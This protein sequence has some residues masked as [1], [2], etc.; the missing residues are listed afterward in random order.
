M[1]INAQREFAYA[2]RLDNSKL[3][4]D[5]AT[6]RQTIEGVG[7]GVQNVG[8]GAQ[9][10]ADPVGRLLAGLN[11][12]GQLGAG[13]WAGSKIVETFSAMAGAIIT[14]QTNADRLI[15]QLGA[16]SGAATAG[17]ELE[18]IRE[19]T[20]RLGLQLNETATSYAR[21][22]ASARGTSL[23]GEGV[24]KIFESVSKASAVMGLTA[25]ETQGALRALEQMMSKG[26]VQAEEL[27]GQLGDRLPGAMQ[28]AARSMGVTTQELQKMVA[29]GEVLANDFLPKFA[30]QLEQELGGG[31]EAAGQRMAAAVNRM[32]NSFQNLS[33]EVLTGAPGKAV[34]GQLDI[35]SDALDNFTERIRD[36]REA[37]GGFW[38][39]LAAGSLAIAQFANP[40]NALG[41][42]ALS[43]ANRLKAANE[44]LVDLQRAL[45]TN[46]GNIFLRESIRDAERL[47][48]S[49]EAV[50]NAKINLRAIDNAMIARTEKEAEESSTKRKGELSKLL[51]TLTKKNLDLAKSE[52]ILAASRAAGEISEKQFLEYSKLASDR[53]SPKARAAA[54]GPAAPEVVMDHPP[55]SLLYADQ[56]RMEQEAERVE[57]FM[58]GKVAESDKRILAKAERISAQAQQMAERLGDDSLRINADLIADAEGRA[59]AML[60]IEKANL[61]SRIEAIGANAEDR[62]A[63]EAAAAQYMLDREKQLTEELKPEWQRRVEAWS[64]TTV[65]M[66]EAYDTMLSG[67]I[68]RGRETWVE[69]LKTGKLN[70]RALVNFIGDELAKLA[71]NKAI[72]ALGGGGGGSALGSALGSL[73]GML[74]IG[75]GVGYGVDSGNGGAGLPGGFDGFEFGGGL[76]TGGGAR[77]GAVHRIN[78]SGEPEVYTATN[79]RRY[80]LAGQQGWVSTMSA[81]QG[82]GGGGGG[83]MVQHITYNV[84][85]GTSP[86]EF[87]AMLDQN[88]RQQRA[89]FA[90][91]VSRPGRPLQ[92][93][94]SAGMA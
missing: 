68:D 22:S 53:F 60:A 49:L 6:A 55:V 83:A 41:Y 40:L 79:G 34:Q 9:E 10:A 44:N 3:D 77:A 26:T 59:R 87:R 43:F 21:F 90:A 78:E 82:G 1:A 17:K 16:A 71:Y 30:R 38:S 35:A 94:V 45:E 19:V 63:L 70:T 20:N 57:Q 73:L 13:G 92:R 2:I 93:A 76:A 27:R 89:Q 72:G 51:E 85:P 29:E 5:A 31:A 15:L 36:A 75:G 84:P 46:P 56:R 58:Q 14:A 18:Y 4:A 37:G 11:G 65:M 62:K 28:I 7:K 48:A 8:Q 81:A 66:R 64:N 86:A 25:D 91:E 69:F 33:Q 12:I 52:R 80:L 50:K 61:S 88:N 74:G 23:E 67:F 24:R 47:V 32:N 54:K 42:D 39:Q